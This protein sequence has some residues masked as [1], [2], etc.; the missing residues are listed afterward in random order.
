MEI[1]INII[2]NILKANLGKV[3]SAFAVK[4]KSI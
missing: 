3:K 4:Q 2:K 1:N